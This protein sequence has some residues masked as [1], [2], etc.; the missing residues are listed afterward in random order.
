MKKLI[1]I[2]ILVLAVGGGY[3]IASNLAKEAVNVSTSENAQATSAILQLS[4]IHI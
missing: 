4:L 2:G 1:L 3:A